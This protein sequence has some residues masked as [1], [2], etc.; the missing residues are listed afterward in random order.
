[1]NSQKKLM[2]IANLGTVLEWAEF[3]FYAYIIGKI[4]QLFF[5]MSDARTGIISAFLIFAI[6]YLTRPLGAIFFGHMGDRF[7]RR[8]ALQASLV[9]MGLSAVGIGLL[10]TYDVLGIASPILLL[11]FRCLQGL[12]VSG[13][14]NGSSIFLM[15][16]AKRLPYLT[17]S[18]TGC[19]SALG[20]TLGSLSA[21]LIALPIMPTWAWRTPFFL[22]IIICAVGVYLRRKLPETPDFLRSQSKKELFKIPLKIVLQSHKSQF[23]LA[24]VLSAA[25]GIYI[26]VGNIFY[27]AYL[28]QSHSL[29]VYQTKLVVTV[30][31]CL[32]IFL[33][34]F[35]SRLADRFNGEKILS[36]GFLL[37]A[38]VGPLLYLLPLTHSLVWILIGQIPYAIADAMV[39]GPLFKY[40]NDLFPTE[41]RY[42][43]VS[44]A[45]SVSMAL[46][47]GTAPM[48]SE[49]LQAGLHL[50]F[51]PA[52]YI[53]LSSI[54][55][56]IGLTYA[57]RKKRGKQWHE[58]AQSMGS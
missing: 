57:T 40:L 7:G 34:P 37:T 16:H 31:S 51:A 53:T 47:A 9:L 25:L 8:N 35:F 44:V 12:A 48:L 29:P 45:W 5:P 20:M 27:A 50:N 43:G 10:P 36:C 33:I 14:F 11:I 49:W 19:A 4:A 41:V 54:L 58:S 56:F 21:M 55:G 38:L 26:Y 52:L 1:M 2:I 13:E 24:I 6:G 17:A 32:V 3:T 23:L 28:E 18:W 15:E 30:G 42:T 22:G 46:F 39:G